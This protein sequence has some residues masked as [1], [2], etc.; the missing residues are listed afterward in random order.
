MGSILYL[1]EVP[2]D[3]GGD[4]M[5]ANM[6]LA[7]E[8]LSEPIRKLIDGLTRST[9]ARSIIVA[10]TAM[11]TAERPIRVPS[12]QLFGRT[13]RQVRNACS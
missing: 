1:T 10:A 3:G 13:P 12:I 6:Y 2:P 8:M 4:T 9:M 11:T 7:Y 5:F